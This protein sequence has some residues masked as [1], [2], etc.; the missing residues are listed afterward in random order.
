[1]NKE[2]IDRALNIRKQVERLNNEYLLLIK[3][4]DHKLANGSSAVVLYVH[5][6]MCGCSIC[7]RIT[8]DI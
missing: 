3:D 4:C 8:K 7:H 2:I 1:M 5:G 6:R